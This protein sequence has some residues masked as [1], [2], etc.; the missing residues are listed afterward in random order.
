MSSDRG[1]NN[2]RRISIFFTLAFFLFFFEPLIRGLPLF[3]P[4]RSVPH[5]V[6]KLFSTC[7]VYPFA[8]IT[9]PGF[10]QVGLFTV[11]PWIAY[12]FVLYSGLIRQRPS[13]KIQ[14]FHLFLW[15]IFAIPLLKNLFS[16]MGWFL[17]RHIPYR[18]HSWSQ[19]VWTVNQAVLGLVKQVDYSRILQEIDHLL[20]FVFCLLLFQWFMFGKLTDLGFIRNPFR[21]RLKWIVVI[22][23]IVFLVHVMTAVVGLY[24]LRQPKPGPRET[25]FF[26]TLSGPFLLLVG[27]FSEQVIQVFLFTHLVKW[28]RPVFFAYLIPGIVRAVLHADYWLDVQIDPMLSASIIVSSAIELWVFSRMRDIVPLWMAHFI[29]D[30]ILISLSFLLYGT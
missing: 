3:V 27:A 9:E 8:H 28:I 7:S 13:W 18:K 22:L 16:F 12:L 19:W 6:A 14:A 29:L 15:F 30:A 11:L 26:F 20:W 10:V 1:L 21:V 5:F 4:C 2:E 17:V 23:G 25:D 24:L